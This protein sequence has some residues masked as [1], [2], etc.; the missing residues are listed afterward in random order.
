M[1]L[2]QKIAVLLMAVMLPVMSITMLSL[3]SVQA[4]SMRQ[5]DEDNTNYALSACKTSVRSAA[6]QH[7]EFVTETTQRSI[8]QYFFSEYAAIA[9]NENTY[10]S[11]ASNGEYLFN[12]SPYDP[13]SVLSE[14]ILYGIRGDIE[15]YPI[16]TQ[17]VASI[18]GDSVWIGGCILSV[19]SQEYT[20]YVS[21]NVSQTENRIARMY[22]IS[23]GMTLLSCLLT[24]VISILLLK[25]ITKPITKLTETAAAI[26]NGEYH[27]RSRYVSADEVGLLSTAFDRMAEAIEE[28]INALDTENERKQFLLGALSHELRTPMTSIVGYGESLVHMP[29]TEEQQLECAYRIIDSGK[30]AEQLSQKMMELVSLSAEQSIEKKFFAA[31]HLLSTVKDVYGGKIEIDCDV[32]NLYGDET[33]L[34]SLISNLIQNG[35]RASREN[36]T[37]K[38]SVQSFEM[39]SVRISVQ[40]HG[41]GIP[42]EYIPRLTEPFYRIDKARSRKMGGAG[43]GLSI[44]KL[45]A[46][47]HGGILNIESEV[48]KGTTISIDIPMYTV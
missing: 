26:A 24:A 7:V 33:L 8:V 29:L 34:F 19:G 12:I 44:C 28:K 39:G 22:F 21:V 23:I 30:R 47:K 14:N 25:H 18:N 3:V 4:N 43:L 35:S 38:V 17:K 27:L 42:E 37:V 20:A 2:W 16:V 48:G 45:I 10:F 31:E 32:Q 41:C 11:L 40:D 46:E 5:I 13:K 36:E 6:E 1:K 15:R 9:R